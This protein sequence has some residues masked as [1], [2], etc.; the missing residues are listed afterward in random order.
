L[1]LGSLRTEE[2]AR[3]E[4]ERVKRANSNLLGSLSAAPIRTDLGDRGVFYRIQTGP[5]A[6]ADRI[7]AELKQRKIGCII[8]R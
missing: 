2:A 8:A 3:H 7:C 6:D 1:Q 5:T 4:W